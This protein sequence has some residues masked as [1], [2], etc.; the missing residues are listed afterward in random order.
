MGGGGADYA[1]SGDQSLPQAAIVAD[2]RQAAI[3]AEASDTQVNAPPGPGQFLYTKTKV[4]QLQGWLPE[5]SETRPAGPKTNPRYFTANMAGNPGVRNALVPT[6]KEVWMAPD[7]TTRE[8][9]TLGRVDFFSGADQRLWEETGSPP[10]F[11]YDPD[12]HDVRRD[13]SG[14]LEKEFASQSW[15]GHRVFS[16]VSQLSKA[17]T[18]PEALR[19][20]LEH[21]RGGSSPVDP[22]PASSPRGGAT[23]ARL[24]EILSEP[25]ASPALHAAAF[26]ALAEIPGIGFERD[27]TDVAG[28]Q[29]DAISWVSERGFG[30][31][32]IFDPHTSKILAQAEMIFGPKATNEYGAPAGTPYRETAYLQSG[33]VNST[34]E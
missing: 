13:S 7:G 12:E 6:L 34:H 33:I 15:R 30:R 25:I 19:L 17:P 31:Q 29:G 9:E 21:R 10:P 16:H 1:P 24:L 26:N 23:V 32:F 11:A 28:R 2:L 14:R 20:A 4:V 3:A 27:V 8:R 22:S 18:D 5:G